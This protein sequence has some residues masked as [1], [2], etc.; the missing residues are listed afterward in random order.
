LGHL[1][2]TDIEV[3]DA[4]SMGRSLVSLS[5]GIIIGGT[6][7]KGATLD[8]LHGKGDTTNG[9]VTILSM[10]ADGTQQKQQ[11][12]CR[13]TDG[14]EGHTTRFDGPPDETDPHER[15]AVDVEPEVQVEE[16]IDGRRTDD[17]DGEDA[18]VDKDEPEQ[19]P[20]EPCT[21]R[22]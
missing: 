2:L 12:G 9:I 13:T 7:H 4:R 22:L 10:D 16:L 11:G 15:H 1:G 19:H 14:E 6:H 17:V 8:V 5:H 21:L 3:G 18:E 20:V